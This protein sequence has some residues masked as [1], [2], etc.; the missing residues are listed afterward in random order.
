MTSKND[1]P[2]FKFMVGDWFKGDI[3]HCSNETRGIFVT[4]C[5]RLWL[6]GGKLAD[7]ERLHKTCGC[8]KQ[9]LSK[10][11]AE[12]ELWDILQYDDDGDVFVSFISQQ[13]TELSALKIKRSEAG[14]KGGKVKRLRKPS[15]AKAKRKQTSSIKESEEEPEKEKEKDNTIPEALNVEGFSELWDD[16]IA[17]RKQMRKPMTDKAKTLMLARCAKEGIIR[18]RYGLNL[19]ME[20]GWQSPVWDHK[21]MPTPKTDPS[22]YANAAD[23]I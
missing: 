12:L 14:R 22:R 23:L 1:L 5:C 7:D 16:F 2:Y 4:L 18:A 11:K 19:A 9:S 6:S 10:A 8:D 13:L 17:N 3:Q 20:R 21:E 15:K